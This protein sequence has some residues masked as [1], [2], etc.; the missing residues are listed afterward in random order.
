MP[1]ENNVLKFPCIGVARRAAELIS[2][3][4][5]H[6]C[7]RTEERN[8]IAAITGCEEAKGCE[9]LA[10]HMAMNTELSLE[11]AKKILGFIGRAC[12]LE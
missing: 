6:A 8:R 10:S 4:E 1:K 11:E 3:A 9:S 7:A 12:A 5:I 2:A